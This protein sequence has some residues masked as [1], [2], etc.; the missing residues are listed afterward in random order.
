[1]LGQLKGKPAIYK[2][3]IKENAPK[4]RSCG[5]ARIRCRRCGRHRGHIK[6]YGLGLC[7]QC[8]GE[9]AQKIGFKQY[10]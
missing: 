9:I 4:D 7:R 1:M 5:I 10:D 2:K 6:K 3:Y 8:F